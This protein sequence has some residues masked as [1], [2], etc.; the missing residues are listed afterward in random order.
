MGLIVR[1]LIVQDVIDRLQAV[2]GQVRELQEYAIMPPDAG[3]LPEQPNWA[4]LSGWVITGT[5][6]QDVNGRI[7]LDPTTPMIQIATGGYIESADYVAGTSGF[8]I[9]GGTAEFNDVTVRGTIY[10]DA[11]EIG[12]WTIG[13]DNIANN[14]ATLHSGGY[15]ILGTGDN[16]VRIDAQDA[17]Y[18][19]WIGNATAAS[20]PF[21]VSQAGAMW[22][23]NAYISGE[24]HAVVFTYDELHANAGIL[25]VFKSA[26]KLRTDCTTIASPTTFNVDIEDPE[27]GHAQLFAASDILRIKDGS[28][29]DLWMSVSSVSDQTTFYRYVCVLQSG[30]AGITIGAGAAVIDYGQS[31]DGFITLDAQDAN[32]PFMSVQTHA[33]SPWS[34]TSERVHIGNMNGVFGVTG[35]YYGIGL[36]DYSGGNYLRYESNGGFVLRAGDGGSRVDAAG[37]GLERGTIGAYPSTVQWY[38]AFGGGETVVGRLGVD[39]TN[40]MRLYSASDQ[41]I[42]DDSSVAPVIQMDISANTV[43]IYGGQTSVADVR[44]NGGLYVGSVATNPAQGEIYATSDIRIGGGLYV[45]AVGTNP[46]ADDIHFDGNLKSVKSAVT[47]DVYGFVPL[48]TPLTSASWDGDSYTTSGASLMDLSVVFGV[49]AGIKAVLLQCAVKDSAA[50][51]NGSYYISFGPSATYYY[52]GSSRCFGGDIVNDQNMII[53]CNSNGDIYYLI[54]ASGTSTLDV[55]LRVFGYF[56]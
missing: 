18:R 1:D 21:R 17:T 28:G 7:I 20:A 39:S 53:P 41:F 12:G 19:L 37:L 3:T 45:G 35:D 33:G 36:G 22:A 13:A 55:W 16:I 27:T 47:Y 8:S 54:N 31:A 9:N 25:G 50:W 34:V 56:I 5:T 4:E 10:A 6:L 38:D 48:T 11:G 15:L 14:D 23:T 32:G 30:T 52:A 49:P 29:Y 46:D 26:G 51:G 24:L 44:L 2:E 40:I 42:G 43:L